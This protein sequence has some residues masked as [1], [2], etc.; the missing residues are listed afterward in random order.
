MG[1]SSGGGTLFD[2]A[3][4]G[5]ER[6]VAPLAVRL[7]PRTLA[8]VLGQEHITG[9][10]TPLRRLVEEG[11]A[12]SLLLWGPPGTGK[13]TLAHVVAASIDGR[14]VEVSAVS[15]GVKDVRQAIDEARR[16]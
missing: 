15:A 12:P 14:F 2:A 1:T 5:A 8:E 11:E 9:P 7:R 6:A 4:D 16:E 3:A 13:T 10:G